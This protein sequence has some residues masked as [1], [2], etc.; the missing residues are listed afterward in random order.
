MYTAYGYDA[1]TVGVIR[2]LQ[3]IPCKITRKIKMSNNKGIEQ[4]FNDNV[5]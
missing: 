5:K 4:L 3:A 2:G 1:V